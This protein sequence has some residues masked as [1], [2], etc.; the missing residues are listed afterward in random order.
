MSRC[1]LTGSAIIYGCNLVKITA[2]VKMMLKA[3]GYP[4]QAAEEA[5]G[6][7]PLALRIR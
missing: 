2:V 1:S 5:D 4:L 7:S 3:T 6:L